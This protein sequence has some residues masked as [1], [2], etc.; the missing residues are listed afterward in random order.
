MQTW[1]SWLAGA[2]EAQPEHKEPQAGPQ[3]GVAVAMPLGKVGPE[4]ETFYMWSNLLLETAASKYRVDVIP[5]W[6]VPTVCNREWIVEKFLAWNWEG[7]R[8][9]PRADWLCWIDGDMTFDNW[10]LS[11]MLE[12]V[13]E[14]PEIKVLSGTA[15]KSGNSNTPVLYERRDNA[16]HHIDAWPKDRLFTVDGVGAFGM[17][18]HRSVFERMSRPFFSYQNPGYGSDDSLNFSSRLLKAEIAVW[19]DPRLPFGHLD[20]REIPGTPDRYM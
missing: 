17:L 9:G 10:Y 4:P 14:H 3:P 18:I 5:S 16:W 13:A 6:G 20:R 7:K 19:I 12:D 15:R 2:G 1:D 8:P 11:R